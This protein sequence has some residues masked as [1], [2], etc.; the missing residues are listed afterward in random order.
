ML[1]HQWVLFFSG[2]VVDHIADKAGAAA[3]TIVDASG[4]LEL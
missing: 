3:G 2:K 4:K 1:M